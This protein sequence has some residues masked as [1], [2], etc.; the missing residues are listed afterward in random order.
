MSALGILRRQMRDVWFQ[1]HA[2]RVSALLCVVRGLVRGGRLSLTA[3]GRSL[4]GRVA[5]R[6]AIKR[7]DRLLGNVHLHREI[8]VIYG[9][10]A[11]FLIGHRI[12][13]VILVDWTD[14]GSGRA[15][16][17]AAIPMFGRAL[18]IYAEVYAMNAYGSRAAHRHFLQT[19]AKEVIPIWS[20]P[21]IVTDAGF[22]NPW[23][24]EV[25]ALGWDVVGR[26]TGHALA[27]STEVS[28]LDRVGTHNWWRVTELHR[29]ATHRAVCLGWWLLTRA[30]PL[31]IRLIAYKKLPAGRKGSRS[32][33]RRG[34]HP[35]SSSYKKYQRRGREPWILATSLEVS[36]TCITRIY[37]E[38]MQIEESF[39]DAKSHRFGWSF[40]DARC[41]LPSS[42]KSHD[43][44]EQTERGS[45]RLEVLLL[46]AALAMAAL[47][48]MGIA[49]ERA[50]EHRAYQANTIRNR[51]VLSHFTLG[52]LAAR[53]P[54]GRRPTIRN[55]T[56]TIAA[57]A[58]ASFSFDLAED[59]RLWKFRGD[60]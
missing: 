13:P 23:F 18:P 26:V 34:V 30:N 28:A 53:A 35:G 4:G 60:P 8:L 11:R 47:Q 43:A 54:P 33:N 25:L 46:I 57:L 56:K 40:E 22:N 6:H 2:A 58:D 29:F 32:G 52:L 50:G 19:L 48:L 51:R 44:K 27:V 59:V 55:L 15:A 10:L 1:I 12:Q 42:G 5:H 3:L 21:V 49:M 17:V 45:R 24:T 7:V 16:L 9:G 14:V 37:A 31:E 41:R 38:R 20:R 39:R 36:P